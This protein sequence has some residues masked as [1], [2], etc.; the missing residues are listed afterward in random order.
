MQKFES[1]DIPDTGYKAVIFDLDGTLVDSMPAHF[2]AWRNALERNNVPLTVFPEDVFYAMGGRPTRD[3]VEDL[4][5]EFNLNL[6]P[7]LVSFAKREEYLKNLDKVVLIDDV[8]NFARSLRGKMPLGIA[9][10]GGRIVVEKTLQFMG[11]SDLFDEV[12]T[13]KDVENGKPAPDVYLEAASRLGVAP[14]DCLAFED[15]PAGMMAAQAA[16]MQVV[17]VPAPLRI[18]S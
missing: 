14:E 6:N 16:G 1:L 3:I 18:I 17:S 9:T 11:I 15:A 10:G 4:N 5:G 2:A 8:I 12:V 7:E 13:A